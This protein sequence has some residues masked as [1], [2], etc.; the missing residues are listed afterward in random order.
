ML[1]SRATLKLTSLK[2]EKSTEEPE[3]AGEWTLLP[4]RARLRRGAT[5]TLTPPSPEN[6]VEGPGTAGEGTPLA[7]GG[8][9]EHG[10]T[11][12]LIPPTT[13]S[14]A[15]LGTEGACP[16]LTPG[17]K[18]G[19]GDT[20]RLAPLLPAATTEGPELGGERD[21]PT[22]G[23]NVGCGLTLAPLSANSENAE[24]EARADKTADN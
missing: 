6:S 9:A 17:A 1:G 18:P 14:G 3:T 5:H 7:T 4:S 2:P 22:P 11:R 23:T 12:K 15:G 20:L 16:P 13:N 8:G 10:A 24:P 21:P 19:R